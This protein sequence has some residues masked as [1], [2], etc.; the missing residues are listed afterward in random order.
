MGRRRWANVKIIQ[1]EETL[2]DDG[3]VEDERGERR[4]CLI[5]VV[6]GGGG[7]GGDLHDIHEDGDLRREDVNSPIIGGGCLGRRVLLKE[8]EGV[9]DV[10]GILDIFNF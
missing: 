8:G 6:G 9:C 3:V 4:F 10:L 7:G 2:E 5:L 1:E